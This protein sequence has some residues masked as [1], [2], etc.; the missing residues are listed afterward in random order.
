MEK[1]FVSLL[2]LVLV[3]GCGRAVAQG[4]NS[5]EHAAKILSKSLQEFRLDEAMGMVIPEDRGVMTVG[6]T[7]A[8]AFM[9]MGNKDLADEYER[10]IEKH[11]V[12]KD[13]MGSMFGKMSDPDEARPAADDALKGVDRDALLRGVGEF[14]KE[15]SKGGGGPMKI[16]GKLTGLIIDGDEATGRLGGKD[17]VFRRIDGRWYATIPLK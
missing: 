3:G 2:A 7:I 4:G 6:L 17:I 12:D 15:H 14:M 13:K 10:M 16:G 8:A 11:G 5:P 1:L 9:T